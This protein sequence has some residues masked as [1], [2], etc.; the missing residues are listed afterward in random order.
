M[1][2]LDNEIERIKK[3]CAGLG[4]K[5]RFIN[6]VSP[7]GVATW[8]ADPYEIDIFTKE[9]KSK[10]SLITSVLHE[11]GHHFYYI[12]NNKPEI[13]DAYILDANRKLGDPPISKIERKKILDY[14]RA[15]ISYMATIATELRLKIPL[16]KIYVRM[17]H[18][19]WVYEQYY[20]NG[21]TPNIKLRK[22][23]LKELTLKYKGK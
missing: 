23:K 20:E 7:V 5:I 8:A 17:D 16:W 18:D 12:H 19:V 1:S 11:L 9:H 10:T 4:I 15:G 2:Y 22:Q 21:D 14:E 13:P 3:Y 6:N